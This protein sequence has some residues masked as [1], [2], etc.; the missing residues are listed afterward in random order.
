MLLG[1]GYGEKKGERRNKLRQIFNRK[2]GASL[3][4]QTEGRPGFQSQPAPFLTMLC[5]SSTRTMM[6]EVGPLK[7]Q[8][9]SDSN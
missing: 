2:V 4:R 8:G 6:N 5:F 3:K 7:I 1:S 9:E